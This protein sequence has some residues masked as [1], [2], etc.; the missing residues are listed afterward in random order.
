MLYFQAF[1]YDPNTRVRQYAAFEY[2]NEIVKGHIK[3]NS[4]LSDLKSGAVKD[5]HWKHVQKSLMA[6]SALIASDLTVG[7]VWD[8]DFKKNEVFFRDLISCAQGE[9]ALE[10]YLSQIKEQWQTFSLDLINYQNKCR[11]VKGWDEIFSKCSEHISSL[12]TMRHSPYFKIFEEDASA[13]ED[14]LNKVYTLF[15]IW[16]DV[17]RQWVYL[18]G[19]F[20]DNADIRHLLPMESSRFAG[21]NSEFFSVLK[22]VYKSPLILDIISIPNIQKSLERL[23][24]LLAKI[25]KALGE[26]LEKERNAFPRFFFVGDEDLL[27]IVGNSK[28][29]G[30]IQ[31]HFRKMFAGIHGLHLDD[32]GGVIVGIF[33]C[34]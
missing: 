22:K 9:N 23:A 18:E 15:D 4:L 25:Q 10:E 32:N 1:I 3:F 17:Q 29:I 30:R 12:R 21:I 26:Y 28:D 19:I 16:I 27:E 5:R 2:L 11:L 14:K 34:E 8:L 20:T 31:K 13:W 33:S 7:R 24:E 6:S